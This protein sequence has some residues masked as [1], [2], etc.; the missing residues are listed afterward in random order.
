MLG[1]LVSR[2]IV[3][4]GRGGSTTSS[5]C[6]VNIAGHSHYGPNPMFHRGIIADIIKVYSGERKCLPT[7]VV[8]HPNRIG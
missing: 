3:L 1:D 4:K 8:N 7:V 6:K 5:G 2:S